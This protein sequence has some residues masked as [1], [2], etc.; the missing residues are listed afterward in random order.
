MCESVCCK[1]KHPS[2]GQQVR[3]VVR[4][5]VGSLG[6]MC[7]ESLLLVTS[8]MSPPVF[9]VFLNPHSMQKSA[10]ESQDYMAAKYG[11]YE[12]QTTSVFK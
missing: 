7:R 10:V 4:E 3:P 9:C 8:D 2:F 12:A 6:R 5:A 1:W 11:E